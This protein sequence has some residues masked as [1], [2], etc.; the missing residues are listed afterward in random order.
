ML[1]EPTRDDIKMACELYARI[2]EELGSEEGLI[3]FKDEQ[4]H[5]AAT[6]TVFIA[7]TDPRKNFPSGSGTPAP[8][9]TQGAVAGEAFN[10]S[11]GTWGFCP[12]CKGP[13]SSGVGSKG[14]WA[15]CGPCNLWLNKNGTTTPIKPKPYP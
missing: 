4:N 7:L 10:K 13:V 6:A 14:P 9:S 15:K 3:S 1:Q 12:V 8:G 5:V 2:F 11:L